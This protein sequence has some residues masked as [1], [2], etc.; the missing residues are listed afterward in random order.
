MHLLH[1]ISS[2]SSAGGGPAEAVRLLS[3]VHTREGHSV[4]VASLDGPGTPQTQDYPFPL[5]ALGPGRTQYSYTPRLLPW[6]RQHRPR[7]DAVI[8]NGLWQ[9]HSFA[10]WRALQGTSTPY[11]VYPHGMLDPWFAR[12]FPLKHAKK[13]LY[14]PW[15]DYRVL[16]DAAAVLF[17]CEEEKLLTRESFWLYRAHE[18]VT[19]LGVS[20]PPGNLDAAAATFLTAYPALR[21]KR[22]AL[23]MGR[24]H[25]KKGCDLLL[26]AFAATLA[27]EPAW[28]LV[29]AGPDAHPDQAGWSAQLRAQAAALGIAERVTW[30]GMLTG[31]L[32]WG[33]LGAAEVFVL[34]SHQENFGIAV[35]EALA[36][37]RPVLITRPVNIW[38]E[39]AQAR[40]GFVAEDTAAG[41][42]ELLDGWRQ[43]PLEEHAA[44]RAR[45]R[46]CFEQ[47]FHIDASAARLLD[48]IRSA[49]A[50]NPGAP[51]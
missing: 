2:V 35:V 6:L 47:H 51:S 16:R 42:R 38:R 23:F 29:M 15:A 7:F 20:E 9:Y 30:P 44:Y 41:A 11:F 31:T 19:G 34:P 43:V 26:D 28:H 50:A 36:C 5:H 40:A 17:T 10:A 3:A 8:V 45:A 49:P 27:R 1:L 14:W 18:L 12:E 33:A 22:L 13:W 46:A 39:I 37:G 32:K 25:P 48:A 21:G 24:L 4:E